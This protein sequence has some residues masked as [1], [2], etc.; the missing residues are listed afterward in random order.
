MIPAIELN[1]TC[2][3]RESLHEHDAETFKTWCVI[4]FYWIKCNETISQGFWKYCK[5]Q[6]SFE[7][8]NLLVKWVN[9][10]NISAWNLKVKPNF[11]FMHC[12]SCFHFNKLPTAMWTHSKVGKYQ[13]HYT[14]VPAVQKEIIKSFMKDRNLQL[15]HKTL[16]FQS[17]C[18]SQPEKFS[19]LIFSWIYS[20]SLSLWSLHFFMESW[21]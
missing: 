10:T 17:V 14:A 19:C 3:C 11:T 18:R 20:L 21:H 13:N 16:N 7:T 9:K 4:L 12:Y 1:T 5:M 6:S 2:C 15:L 8:Y